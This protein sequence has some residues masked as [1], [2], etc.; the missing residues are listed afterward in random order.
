MTIQIQ[1]NKKTFACYNVMEHLPEVGRWVWAYSEVH[2]EYE[3]VSFNPSIGWFKQDGK[4][5]MVITHW[6]DLD[7]PMP[8]KVGKYC[9]EAAKKWRLKLVPYSGLVVDVEGPNDE[10][11]NDT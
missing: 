6:W 1:E 10:D 8:L 2:Q 9:E 4:Q 3:V 7:M 5:A 11:E